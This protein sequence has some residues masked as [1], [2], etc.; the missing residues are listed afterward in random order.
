MNKDADKNKSNTETSSTLKRH[1]VSKSISETTNNLVNISLFKK[2]HNLNKMYNHT[3]REC[4]LC[5]TKN[6]MKIQRQKL[7]QNYFDCTDIFNAK[8][9]NEIIYNESTNIVSIFKDY[10]IYDDLTEF[11]KRF[12]SKA[13]L[14]QR[15]NKIFDFYSKYSKVFPNYV[16]IFE[17]K[18]MFKNIERKQKMIDE[19]QKNQ[20]EIKNK[21]ILGDSSVEENKI[22]TTNFMEELNKTHNILQNKLGDI[23]D[24]NSNT[25]MQTY[26]KAGAKINQNNPQSKEDQSIRFDKFNLQ[27]LVENFVAKDSQSFIETS[28]IKQQP[29]KEVKKET[30]KITYPK[31]NTDKPQLQN[32]T[33]IRTQSNGIIPKNE[34]K[35]N[36]SKILINEIQKRN[37]NTERDSRNREDNHTFKYNNSK[38]TNVQNESKSHPNPK[39]KLDKNINSKPENMNLGSKNSK[40]LE[41]K[42]R[43]NNE[44]DIALQIIKSIKGSSAQKTNEK[45]IIS[46]NLENR[47]K[48]NSK[49]VGTETSQGQRKTQEENEREK[50]INKAKNAN[51][52]INPN[53]KEKN[54]TIQISSEPH[55]K[56]EKFTSKASRNNPTINNDQKNNY[57]TIKESKTSG[58]KSAYKTKYN[59]QK[60]NEAEEKTLNYPNEQAKFTYPAGLNSLSPEDKIQIENKKSVILNKQ[61]GLDSTK[62]NLSKSKRT[63][64]RTPKTIGIE[65]SNTEKDINTRNFQHTKSA[66]KIVEKKVLE[67]KYEMKNKD[68]HDKNSQY[69]AIKNGLKNSPIQNNRLANS[70]SL[71]TMRKMLAENGITNKPHIDFQNT[72]Y[73]STS[74]LKKR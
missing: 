63:T 26:L 11:L 52:F 31:P 61:L 12:Y 70:T 5:Q 10:L 34:I 46:Q 57:Y 6:I 64:T 8:I 28:L 74:V 23:P 24:L 55:V 15:L 7:K 35:Q 42:K 65:Q 30:V 66:P 41:I 68:A 59:Q 58:V 62:N 37:E 14:N 18:F 71:K 39:I 38:I 51:H 3:S 72:T 49:I 56:N 60:I 67:Q 43:K 1:T 13:E 4:I 69:S 2:N 20:D 44:E 53:R 21:K 29:L 36:P 22:F 45:E 17:K 40:T 32:P 54:P 33:H 27:E 16:N 9:I 48:S 73:K 47:S 19:Q 25:K 50:F